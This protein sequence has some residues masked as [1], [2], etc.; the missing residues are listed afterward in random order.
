M[1]QESSTKIS[2]CCDH[3]LDPKTTIGEGLATQPD[4]DNISI[5]YNQDM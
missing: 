4:F 2:N 1:Q 3:M 5:V